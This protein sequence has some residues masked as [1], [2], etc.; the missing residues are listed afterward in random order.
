MALRINKKLQNFPSPR[1][2]SYSSTAAPLTQSIIHVESS[3]RQTEIEKP[4]QLIKME[5]INEDERKVFR[6][7]RDGWMVADEI[8]LHN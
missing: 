7:R 3:P 5:M 1:L 2:A 8:T 6:G 4:R